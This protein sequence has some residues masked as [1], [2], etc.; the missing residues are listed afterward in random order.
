LRRQS[1]SPLSEEP[2]EFVRLNYD[3]HPELDGAAGGRCQRLT[4]QQRYAV[5][6]FRLGRTQE[7]ASTPKRWQRSTVGSLLLGERSRLRQAFF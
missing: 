7:S 4:V 3:F 5:S 2:V 6:H 1:W